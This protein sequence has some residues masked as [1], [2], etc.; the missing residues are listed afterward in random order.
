MEELIKADEVA[1][2]LSVSTV[3]VYAWAREGKLPSYRLLN[4]RRCTRFRPE[5]VRE[6]VKQI[7]VEKNN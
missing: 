1:K 2:M 5:D 3:T 4:R 7:K 6:L